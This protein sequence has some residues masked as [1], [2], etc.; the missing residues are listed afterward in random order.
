MVSF[1]EIGVVV[2]G[3]VTS[4]GEHLSGSSMSGFGLIVFV[5]VQINL[6]EVGC[7][8]KSSGI[9]SGHGT[10]I[11]GSLLGSKSSTSVIHSVGLVARRS[12]NSASVIAHCE[13]VKIKLK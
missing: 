7:V 12:L 3:L 5:M 10:G 2:S 9:L 13:G 8:S 4:V 11:I 1:A 6:V